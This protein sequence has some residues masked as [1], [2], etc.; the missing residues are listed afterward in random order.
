MNPAARTVTVPRKSELEERRLMS[1]HRGSAGSGRHPATSKMR[2]LIR[3]G[4]EHISTR[5]AEGQHASL[6]HIAASTHRL[7]IEHASTRTKKAKTQ[8]LSTS[9]CPD[10]NHTG[11]EKSQCNSSKE[12]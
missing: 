6:A 4:N 10:T 5:T 8:P 12:K 7:C 2:D 1:A 9:P 3:F 11:E